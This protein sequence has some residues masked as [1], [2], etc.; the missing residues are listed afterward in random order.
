LFVGILRENENAGIDE[1]VVERLSIELDDCLNTVVIEDE[2]LKINPVFGIEPPIARNESK[3]PTVT[4]EL[5]AM[6]N[7]VR[8]DI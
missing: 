5:G 2:L 7:E 8:V 4:K 1:R 3:P 6:R